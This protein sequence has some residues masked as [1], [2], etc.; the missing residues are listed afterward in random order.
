MPRETA[1][2]VDIGAKADELD[3]YFDLLGRAFAE[4]LSAA[5]D[6]A[7]PPAPRSDASEQETTDW[8]AAPPVSQVDPP[9]PDGAPTSETP[10]AATTNVP[11][12]SPLAETFAALLAAEQDT[13]PIDP[14]PT[15]HAPAIDDIVEQVSHR[16]LTQLHE[17][18]VRETIADLVAGIAERLVREE[19]ERIKASIK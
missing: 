9:T 2:A 5:A 15:G 18:V 7:V 3:E 13:R 12:P 14:T 16:V 10:V 4:R 17:R 6:T 19:I 8:S 11:T 1:P